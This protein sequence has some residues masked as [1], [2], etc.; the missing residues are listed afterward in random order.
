MQKTTQERQKQLSAEQRNGLYQ[1]IMI[2][3]T[4]DKKLF[5]KLVNKQRNHYQSTIIEL[6][7]DD[8]HVTDLDMIRQG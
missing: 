6:I 3:H 8:V 4:A 5:Y 7:I 2:T 1:E